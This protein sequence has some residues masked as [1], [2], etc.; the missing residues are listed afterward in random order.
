MSMKEFEISKNDAIFFEN[1]INECALC[2]ETYE[3]YKLLIEDVSQISME[4]PPSD[5]GAKLHLRLVKEADKKRVFV[6]KP[7]INVAVSAALIF[8]V[9]FG[10]N[11]SVN[12]YFNVFV[13]SY[14][15]CN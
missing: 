13:C 15:P 11:Y 2:K 8:A 9:A 5:F 6:F 12:I 4:A 14:C 7:Y 10:A 3:S 1:H